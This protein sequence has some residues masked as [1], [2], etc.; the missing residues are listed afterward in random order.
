MVKGRSS[1]Q[2]VDHIDYPIGLHASSDTS[3][4]KNI[5]RVLS[6]QTRA[7]AP[8]SGG[9]PNNIVFDKIVYT[10]ASLAAKYLSHGELGADFS[11]PT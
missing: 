11:S 2:K 6:M 5:G 9:M 3:R 10:M 4:E 7:G 1:R 8:P